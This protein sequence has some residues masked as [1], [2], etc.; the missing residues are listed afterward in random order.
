MINPPAWR[1]SHIAAAAIN[2]AGDQAAI[3]KSRELTVTSISTSPTRNRESLRDNYHLETGLGRSLEHIQYVPLSRLYR[4]ETV[5]LTAIILI[6]VKLWPPYYLNK[7]YWPVP[8]YPPSST[9]FRLNSRHFRARPQS[10]TG[11]ICKISS[12]GRLSTVLCLL[13]TGKRQK[14]VRS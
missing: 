9:S 10:E 4:S 12:H 14:C 8:A 11:H 3:I 2:Q 1:T 5:K 13:L 7:K 6:A